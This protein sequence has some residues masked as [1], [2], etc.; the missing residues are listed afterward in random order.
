MQARPTNDRGRPGWVAGGHG[1]TTLR[2]LSVDQLVADTVSFT[3]AGLTCAFS[4]LAYAELAPTI[5]VSGSAHTY[6][7]ATMGE[8]VAW[9][10]GWDLILEYGI[11]V[12]AVAV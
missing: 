2:D 11:S 5:P 3:L 12:A 4:A 1:V 7:Y 9:I 6:A 8:L 10:I